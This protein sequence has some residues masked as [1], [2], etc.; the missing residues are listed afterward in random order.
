MEWECIF[1]PT[2]CAVSWVLGVAQDT[3]IGQWAAS[4]WAAVGQTLIAVGTMWISVPTPSLTSASAPTG[5]ISQVL[6]YLTTSVFVASL[7]I[8]GIVLAWRGRKEPLRDIGQGMLLFVVVNGAGT[9][10][11]QVLIELGDEFSTYVLDGANTNPEA[12]AKNMTGLVF[13][14]PSAAT[15]TALLVFMGLIALLANLVQVVLMFAR[16]GLLMLMAGFLPMMAALG[17]SPAGKAWLKKGVGWALAFVLYKPVAALIYAVS[18]RL[19]STTTSDGGA[20]KGIMSAVSRGE[21]DAAMSVIMAGA[22]M[23]VSVFALPALIAFLV[24]ST[25]AITG[26]G[27]GSGLAS[28]GMAASGAVSVAGTMRGMSGTKAGAA[29]AASAAP[30]AAAASA[31]GAGI[32]AVRS[33][34]HSLLSS[35]G[36]GGTQGEAGSPGTPG[37]SGAPGTSGASGRT[38]ASGTSGTQGASGAASTGTS[39]SSASGS[40]QPARGSGTSVQPQGSAIQVLPAKGYDT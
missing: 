18:I 31:V 24:P 30:P 7:T 11:L 9:L 14:T 40:E 29:A 10:I 16:S 21:G 20:Y 32:S 6:S 36:A 5:W 25:Q 12:F 27:G 39:T 23:V 35:A 19:M 3:V 26:G 37:A 34:T 2:G 38:G 22:L 15:N 17:A 8:S 4:L 33:T 1:D 28:M 13:T